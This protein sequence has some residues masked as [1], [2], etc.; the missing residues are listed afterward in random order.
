MFGNQE[1]VGDPGQ[2]VPRSL[3]LGIGLS[4]HRRELSEIAHLPACR[5]QT[6]IC[7]SGIQTGFRA[8]YGFAL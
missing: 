6:L 4:G 5:W 7:S 3:D 2:L 8:E 1:A